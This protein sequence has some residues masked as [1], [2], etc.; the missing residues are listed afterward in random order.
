MKKKTRAMRKNT[1]HEM[2]QRY[3][4]EKRTA[5]ARDKLIEAML[6]EGACHY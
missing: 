2:E 5:A 6:A 1:V 4:P 3:L